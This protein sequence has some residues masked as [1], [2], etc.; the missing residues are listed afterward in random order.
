MLCK[1]LEYVSPH[2][3]LSIECYRTTCHKLLGIREQMTEY[4][5]G[6]RQERKIVFYS[7]STFELVDVMYFTY[8]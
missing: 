4:G 8:V 2:T 1:H 6:K 3:F 7:E 5:H